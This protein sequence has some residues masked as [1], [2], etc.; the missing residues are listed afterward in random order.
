ME[1]ELAPLVAAGDRA[2]RAVRV[3]GVAP[4]GPSQLPRSLRSLARAANFQSDSRVY[5]S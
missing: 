3:A 2:T 4:M 1:T 5:E